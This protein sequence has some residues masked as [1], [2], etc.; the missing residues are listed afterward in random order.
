[1]SYPT[2]ANGIIVLLNSLNSENSKYEIR[3][4][5]ARKSVRNR[6]KVDQ[7][8]MLCNT[9]WS[10]RR[11]LITKKHFLPFRVL[12]NVGIDPNFPQK[13][14]G[15]I[16]RKIVLSG[17]NIFSNHLPYKVKLRYMSWWPR[18]SEPIRVRK[19]HYPRLKIFIFKCIHIIL[20]IS[21]FWISLK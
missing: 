9:L 21:V 19:M 11:R 6:K 10:D 3:A 2:S 1:M 16:Q 13:S 12:L 18:L 5:K 15:F 4:K 14:F 7:D 8:A 20:Y 17:E